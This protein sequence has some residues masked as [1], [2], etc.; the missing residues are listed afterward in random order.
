MDD[1]TPDT[2]ANPAN[3][4]LDVFGPPSARSPLPPDPLELNATL[5][6][7]AAYGGTGRGYLSRLAAGMWPA[8]PAASAANAAQTPP[9]SGIATDPASDPL[10]ADPGY[11]LRLQQGADAIERSAAARGTLLSGG[12]LRALA[13]FGQN[14]AGEEYAARYRRAQEAE[15]ERYTRA[16]QLARLGLDA[17]RARA[18]FLL[19]AGAQ[20]AAVDIPAAFGGAG[21]PPDLPSIPGVPGGNALDPG[22]LL[23]GP[24]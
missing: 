13:E 7:L 11:R 4:A 21:V 24:P 22:Y 14:L 18:E 5:R 8:P 2:P 3:P 10:E 6:R 19:R 1:T 23:F 15:N 17:D 20:G 9:A 16:L 12:T